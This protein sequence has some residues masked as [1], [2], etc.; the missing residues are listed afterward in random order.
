LYSNIKYLK[1][2]NKTIPKTWNEMMDT[3]E[4]IL[5]REK[6]LNKTE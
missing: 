6:E 2:Y 3:G 4:Y 1:K 5:N